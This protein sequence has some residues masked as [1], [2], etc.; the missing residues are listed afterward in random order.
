M[1]ILTLGLFVYL[2]AYLIGNLSLSYFWLKFT[3][4][5][6]LR[7]MGSGSLGARNT[8]RYLGRKGF[9]LTL[10]FDV[11]K[12]MAAMYVA[13]LLI[14]D[15]NYLY[16]VAIF[17]TAGHIWPVL[18]GFKG[19]KG[20]ATSLG[21]FA[22]IDLNLVLIIGVLFGLFYLFTR[23]FTRSGLLG[24]T[25]L[26]FSLL[27]LKVDVALLFSVALCCVMV[28]WAH[29]ANIKEDLKLLKERAHE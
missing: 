9:V 16:P 8:G 18:L 24:Y 1:D 2:L 20:I 21:A 13:S 29:R 25:L 7:E 22:M 17:V 28:L 10:L 19:G 11:V 5:G 3:Q 27:I 26:P 6:D 23:R 14:D 15:P 12:G 4:Q